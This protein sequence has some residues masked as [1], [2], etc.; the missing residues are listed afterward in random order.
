MRLLLPLPASAK[1]IKKMA[2]L[3]DG[4]ESDWISRVS[5]YTFDGKHYLAFDLS[6]DR[7]Q[8]KERPREAKKVSE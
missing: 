3:L 6:R 2:S 5:G 4:R 7:I 1:D 8:R